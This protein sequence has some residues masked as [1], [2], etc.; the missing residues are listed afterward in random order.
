MT[1]PIT[2]SIYDYPNLYDV[3]FSD[4]CRLEIRFLT[5]IFERFRNGKRAISIFEPACGSG[6][7]LYHLAKLGWN[8]SGLDLNPH[9]IAFC[10]RRLKRYGFRESAIVGNMVSCSLADWGRTKKFDI[11][12]NFVSSFLHLTTEADARQHLQTIA[13]ILKPGGIYLLGIHL[14]PAGQQLC[15]SEHWSVRRGS[16]TIK[17]Y[18]KSLTQDSKKRIETVEF[19]IEAETPTKCYRII[20]RFPLRMYTAKQFNDLLTAV[21]RFDILETYSF[22]YDLSRP[23]EVTDDTEDVVFVLRSRH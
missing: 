12:F 10:N 22:D 21:T 18:L 23:I 6:R 3:L 1:H 20:D 4:L 8:V 16:L 9:A 13:D 11:A 5:S 2:G 15:A 7:L 14:K 17:S 19:R